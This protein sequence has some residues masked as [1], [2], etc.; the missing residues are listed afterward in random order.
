MR[1]GRGRMLYVTLL[2]NTK[3][4]MCT[5]TCALEKVENY[6][7]LNFSEIRLILLSKHWLKS[8]KISFYFKTKRQSHM[9]LIEGVVGYSLCA[10]IAID[11]EKIYN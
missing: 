8:S 11:I 9:R 3:L 5:R 1:V 10:H 2:K 6:I 4:S 7:A